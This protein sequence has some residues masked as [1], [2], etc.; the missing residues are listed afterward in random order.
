[1]NRDMLHLKSVLWDDPQAL[2]DKHFMFVV[3]GAEDY[4]ELALYALSALS[5]QEDG[6]FNHCRDDAAGRTA[7]HIT[8]AIFEEQG[9]FDPY[10]DQEFLS[11]AIEL[12]PW[13]VK[14]YL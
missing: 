13:Y 4:K 5:L 6:D 7:H 11:K 1:M 3:Y 8:K 12:C 2:D 10:G 9:V 14:R